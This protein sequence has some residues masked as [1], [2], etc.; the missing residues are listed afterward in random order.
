MD[1]IYLNGFCNIASSLS[2]R[3][4]E[5]LFWDRNPTLAGPFTVQ[6]NPRSYM[7]QFDVFLD[8]QFYIRN[9]TPL[10]KRG[11]VLQES[12]LSPRTI[13]FSRFPAF[14]C[15]ECF[16]CESYRAPEPESVSLVKDWLLH[17]SKTIFDKSLF[18]YSDW[19]ELVYDYSRC[20]LTI[21]TDRLIAL[22]GITR[23]LSSVIPG[24]YYGG[25][26]SKWW[27]P[28]LL[29]SVDQWLSGYGM[30]PL[31]LDHEYVGKSMKYFMV[32]CPLNSNIYQLPLGLGHPSRLL[33]SHG[34]RTMQLQI[35]WST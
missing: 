4:E 33:Y 20:Q 11:W 19:W 21:S 14:E 8:L 6:F 13:H 17:T 26:W 2:T 23:A 5:G 10:Y 34:P 29:W 35:S 16:T 3:P 18:G 31:R 32:S 12:H 9:N 22:S 28:G 7:T 30:S 24:S 27:L 1:K 25:I 15:R